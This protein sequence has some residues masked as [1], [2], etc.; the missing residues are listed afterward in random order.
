MPSGTVFSSP[1]TLIFIPAILA[2]KPGGSQI[3][4]RGAGRGRVMFAVAACR[5]GLRASQIPQRGAGRGRVMF[6]VAACRPG[7]RASRVHVGEKGQEPGSVKRELGRESE[8]PA[9]VRHSQLLGSALVPAFH[10][11]LRRPAGVVRFQD[12]P[13]HRCPGGAGGADQG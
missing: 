8:C 10:Q 3:P 5:P 1:F 2:Q 9:V 6:A 13:D 7:L 12:P 11:L 4:Q